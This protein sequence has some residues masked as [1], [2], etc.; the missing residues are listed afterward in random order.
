[1]TRSN[2]LRRLGAPAVAAAVLVAALAGLPQGAAAQRTLPAVQGTDLCADGGP[3]QRGMVTGNVSLAPG[4]YTAPSCSINVQGGAT[5][6]LQSGVSIAFGESQG[7]TVSTGGTLDVQG[8]AAGDVRLVSNAVATAPGDW[9]GLTFN[10]GSRA[11]LRGLEVRHA[12]RNAAPT[13]RILADGVTLSN[14]HLAEGLG[15]GVSV[16]QFGIRIEDTIVEAHGREGIVVQPQ[17]GEALPV[18]ALR[19]AT[20]RDN[21][22]AAVQIGGPVLLE[23]S[24][25]RAEDNGINAIVLSAMTFT[26]DAT[27]AGGDLP[28]VFA[29]VV[30]VRGA[31]LSIGSGALIKFGGT[32]SADVRASEGGRIEIVGTAEEPV[33][34]TAIADDSTCPVARVECDTGNDGSTNPLSNAWRTLTFGDDSGGGRIQHA[35]LRYGGG[36]GMIN[37]E[38]PGVIVDQ[39]SVSFGQTNGLRVKEADAAITASTFHANREAGVE[40]DLQEPISVTLRGNT[41]T[42]NAV[43]VDVLKADV[44]LHTGDNET[45]GYSNGINGYRISGDMTTSHTWRAG[46]LPFVPS[47]RVRVSQTAATLRIE[48]GTVVKLAPTSGIESTRGRIDV[49]AE[50]ET[51]VLVTSLSDDACSADTDAGC[52]TNGDGSDTRP[53]P[54]DWDRIEFDENGAGGAIVNATIRYGGTKTSSDEQIRVERSQVVLQDLDIASGS[55]AGVLIAESAPTLS[56]LEIHDNAAEGLVVTTGETPLTIELTGTSIYD[57]GQGGNE[58]VGALQVDA[59]VE[60]V[61][62]ET[63]RAWRDSGAQ[64]NGIVV[65]GQASANR[66]WRATSLPFVILGSVDVVDSATLTIDPGA[67]VRFGQGAKLT[68]SR[69]YLEAVGTAEQPILFTAIS[70][71]DN[72]ERRER[73]DP[74]AGSPSPGSWG[75]LLINETTC[76][77]GRE[78]CG[79]IEHVRVRYTGRQSQPGILI[80]QPRTLVRRSEVEH[81]AAD[82]I[83]V[84]DAEGVEI[85]ENTIRNANG[86]GINAQ[87]DTNITLIA[88]GNTIERTNAAIYIAA[89]VQLNLAGEAAE[90]NTV[91][92]NQ[93][94]GV[95]VNGD[96][97]TVRT[98]Q[99]D[100]LVWVIEKAV[101]IN[102]GT[103]RVAPG[104]VVK[105]ALGAVLSLSRGGL[106]VGAQETDREVL[107]TSI[108]DDRC[109]VDDAAGGCDTDD[110]GIDP[111]PGDWQGVVVERGSTGSAVTIDHA[112]VRYG[113]T[114]S[115]AAVSSMT[116][117]TTV[118][119]SRIHESLSD[120]LGLSG[121]GALGNPA[122]VQGN[123]LANNVGSGLVMSEQSHVRLVG[124]VFTGNER[125]LVHRSTGEVATASNVA[126][127]NVHD[128]MLYCA[129]VERTQTWSNDL[130]REIDCVVSVVQSSDLTIEPGT[131]LRLGSGDSL[132]VRANALRA[133]GVVFTAAEGEEELTSPWRGIEF[134]PNTSGYLRHNLVAYG[135]TTSG[136]AVIVRS[137]ID[138]SFNT[139]LRTLS[140]AVT[141]EEDVDVDLVGNTIRTIRGARTAGIRLRDGREARVENNHFDDMENGIEIREKLGEMTR[142][143]FA[144]IRQLGINQETRGNCVD[145]RYNWWGDAFGPGDSSAA[146]DSCPDSVKTNPDHRD[147]VGVSDGVRYREWLTQAP[148]RIPLVELPRSGHTSQAAQR[149]IGRGEPGSSIRVYDR[150]G[151]AADE[152]V[153]ATAVVGPDGRFEV[154]LALAAGAHHLSVE[155]F[156]PYAG[157]AAGGPTELRS[158]RTGYRYLTVD[159]SSAIDPASILFEYGPAGSPRRQPLRDLAGA[160]TACGGASSGRVVIPPGQTVVVQASG[161][162]DLEFVQDGAP[163][164]PLAASGGV[165]RSQPFAPQQGRFALRAPGGAAQCEG[166]VF[167]GGT[168]R[169]YYDNGVDDPPILAND[170]EAESAAWTLQAPW[171]RVSDERHGGTWSIHSNPGAKYP[172]DT[173]LAVTLVEPVDLR[174]TVAPRLNFWHRYRFA[175]GDEARVQYKLAFEDTWKNLD[176]DLP[177]DR[178]TGVQTTW[179][180][181]T[182]SLEPFQRQPRVYLRFVLVSNRDANVDDGWW[183]DDISIGSGGALNGRYDEGEELISGATVQL[184]QRDPDPRPNPATGRTEV[185]VPWNASATNQTNPQISDADG[186]FGF[187]SLPPG[188]YMLL[189]TTGAGLAPYAS[190][191]YIVTDGT[192]T[193]DVPLVTGRGIYFP[194]V[195]NRTPIGR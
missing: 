182:V 77:S 160:A 162:P 97:R 109:A 41:F 103:L 53:L 84:D 152:A 83:E 107:L 75:G 13:L 98:W 24:D 38:G 110:T 172:V 44:D 2:L 100:D 43:A 37:I 22:G 153:V 71:D 170:F 21:A 118:R 184:L 69:G 80:R 49:G 66:R 144:G 55:G 70:D 161:P 74:G 73:T 139:F 20:L 64:I 23:A 51:P 105:G 88:R 63:N 151:T 32:G 8:A 6:T 121:V 176:I 82:G 193:E 180:P 171:A 90:R 58:A 138:V 112:E 119:S 165:L 15:P 9:V 113:G 185:W 131:L 141:V 167:I 25:N 133:E 111:A 159:A 169:V 59:N 130:A 46:D 78:Y 128:P 127:G 190:K 28:F 115:R 136:G 1:M 26:Q 166:F 149:L 33:V 122:V 85:L 65:E 145:G 143:N 47:G 123:M 42:E 137:G 4:T 95:L 99:A 94:N 183:L 93:V 3:T 57:N 18:V 62:D 89:N 27:F 72:P 7:L 56:G 191:P 101:R 120:G 116:P 158:P 134:G 104:A 189:V 40:I 87:T 117:R 54:G 129:A 34:L 126:I 125:S 50:G 163:P 76:G 147:G 177:G 5:L 114:T 52:D 164:V 175:Q 14:V 19:N 60:L 157:G 108:R 35:E 154:P 92:D 174:N 179:T 67:I 173:E 45:P 155:A 11:T 36:Q 168:G 181:K 68:T 186:R 91:T 61:L 192:L 106:E 188:E 148:P 194:V 39:V 48:P 140:S 135:G 178:I 29:G 17:S 150:A 12:G 30:N 156:A 195:A 96:V 81:A 132:D 142:N 79:R 102:D 187:F 124:N 31:T 16:S 86:H 146:T 10:R